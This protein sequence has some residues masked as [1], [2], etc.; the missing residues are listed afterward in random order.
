MATITTKELSG[1]SDHLAD[2]MNLVAKYRHYAQTAQD[3][4]LKCKYEHMAGR[5]QKHFEDLY[6]NLK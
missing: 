1:L 4:A 2:E 5:H 6:S 3:P